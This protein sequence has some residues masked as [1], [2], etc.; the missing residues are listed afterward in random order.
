[1]PPVAS[2]M[3]A[4]AEEPEP[5][6][7]AVVAQR[8]DDPIAVGEQPQHGALHVHVDALVDAVVLQG[9]DHLETR[10]VAHVRE[11][12]I[13]VPAEV[14][15]EDPAV[16]RAVEQGAPRLELAHPRGRL[17]GVQ[18]GHAPVV[19]VLPAAHGVGEVDLPAVAVVHVGQGRGHAALRHHRVRLAEERLAHQA[20]AHAR[21]GRG[22]GR[23]QAGAARADHEH[24]VLERLVIAQRSRQS[25]QMP[26][27]QSRM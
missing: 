25:V 16:G 10:A 20:D 18:L 1:M 5:A 8:P 27:E 19:D 22:D 6:A 21:A 9:A 14:A 4:A 13:L 26:I 23:A 2:T 11:P 7:L 15:L 12:R 3:A 24:V 17:L